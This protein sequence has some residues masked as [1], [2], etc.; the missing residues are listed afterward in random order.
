MQRHLERSSSEVASLYT[1]L[2]SGLR[3]NKAS[4]DAAGLAISSTLSSDARVF[5]QAIRNINDG[6]S[7][8]SIAQGALQELSSITT[9][10]LE[11]VEQGA[12]GVYTTKQR[13]AI[14]DEALAL[15][16]EYNRI[17]STT[18]FNG[19]R[20]LDPGGSVQLQ[21]GF[22][23]DGIISIDI[24]DLLARNT[25]SGTYSTGTTGGG[26]L[27]DY[28][29]DG[30]LDSVAVDFSNFYVRLNDGS[31][32]FSNATVSV[33]TG[34]SVGTV[35]FGDF[36]GDGIVDV[37]HGSFYDQVMYIQ[38][39]STNGSFGAAQ[40]FSVAEALTN[41]AKS[42]LSTD[43]DN[44]GDL[45]L[46]AHSRNGS[47]TSVY[48]NNNGSFSFL[49]SFSGTAGGGAWAM[50][51]IDQDGDIDLV[52]AGQIRINDG[53]GNFVN[54]S[55]FGISTV[56]VTGAVAGQLVDL[57]HDGILDYI[58]T[59]G[60]GAG[61]TIRGELYVA[62]GKGDGTFNQVQSIT[63]TSSAYRSNNAYLS[64]GDMN[65]DGHVDIITGDGTGTRTFVSYGDGTGSFA[66]TSYSGFISTGNGDLN[67]DGV[68][69]INV[70][71]MRLQGTTLSPYIGQTDLFTQ[72]QNRAALT[73]F[74]E[75]LT[76][77]SKE[78]GMI[79]AIQSRLD[80]A[81]T[82]LRST[83]ENYLAANARIID[84]DVASNSAALVKNQILQQVASSVLAQA[85]Q[86]P[87]LALR[88]LQN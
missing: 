18:T 87:A 85:N 75:Q 50:G 80:V 54:G 4:D 38:H 57:N 31:G 7:L 74:Q 40:T 62:L 10:Q 9:R 77:I 21:A 29:R 46:V 84:A 67:N 14:N 8:L 20:I 36:N 60:E 30:D 79:G 65:G 58:S 81:S 37:A 13:K 83:T 39:G 64:Y 78:I 6:Q 3:I 76:R 32:N 41:S 45:D 49:S 73:T 82:T 70:A 17:I 66:V 59:N 35:A 42:V 2:S 15:T 52:A 33:A 69:D 61:S 11:L 56:Q 86:L 44:D 48:L 24:A 51:D 12:N 55:S 28:D 5:T 22:G 88:L 68:S 25:G 19:T 53:R 23:S 43:I 71:T 63:L 72:S 1:R 26:Y 34:S 27:I 16:K 47:S